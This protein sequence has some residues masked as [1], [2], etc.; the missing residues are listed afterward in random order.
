[1]ATWSS[2]VST[3]SRTVAA[4]QHA[5]TKPQ[6]VSSAS[7]TSP[8]S[9]SGFAICQH[10]LGIRDQIGDQIAHMTGE[11]AI[12]LRLAQLGGLQQDARL[13]ATRL[14]LGFKQQP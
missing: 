12:Q 2:V 7:S 4:W 11:F 1:C 10:D 3:S 13:H 14:G 6:T 8:A 9:G 5:T